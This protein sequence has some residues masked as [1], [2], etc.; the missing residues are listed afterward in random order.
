MQPDFQS[1]ID[2]QEIMSVT[3]HHSIGAV[4][5]YEEISCDQNEQLRGHLQIE[6]CMLNIIVMIRGGGG[7]EGI[8]ILTQMNR[9][10]T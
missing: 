1:E 2:E 3:G 4:R 9:N 6:V 8:I 7:V 5:I 10:E